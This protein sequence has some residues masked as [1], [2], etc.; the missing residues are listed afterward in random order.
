MPDFDD[1][2]RSISP[3]PAMHDAHD[4]QPIE[5]S[6]LE[7]PPAP[8]AVYIQPPVE[9]PRPVEQTRSLSPTPPNTELLIKYSEAQAEIE[10]LRSLLAAA[11][12]PT[13]LRQRSNRHYADDASTVADSDVGTAVDDRVAPQEGVPPQIVALV[14]FL[15]FLVTYLFF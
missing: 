12:P 13:E 7:V 11:A 14:G 5:D 3:P 2:R 15:I 9:P 1:S 6:V 4:E 10:R 8:V